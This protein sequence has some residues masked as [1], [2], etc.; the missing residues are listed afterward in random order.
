M[1]S[2]TQDQQR[3]P[4]FLICGRQHHKKGL[5]LL[6]AVFKELKNLEWKLI[7]VG[8]DD[9][10]S[11]QRFINRLKHHKLEESADSTSQS[12]QSRIGLDLQRR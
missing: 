7:L 4:L 1:A 11:G 2:K 5:D 3:D 9:D 8:H 10:G 6:P 12:A